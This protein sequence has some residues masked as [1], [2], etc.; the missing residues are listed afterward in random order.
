MVKIRSP[1]T[2]APRDVSKRS[3]EE[4]HMNPGVPS[5]PPPTR[6]AD[7]SAATPP[8]GSRGIFTHSLAWMVLGISLAASAG[9]C[10]HAVSDY[11]D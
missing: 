4:P 9:G 6:P 11:V 3:L 7:R 1:F 10:V 5:L 2:F 8:R